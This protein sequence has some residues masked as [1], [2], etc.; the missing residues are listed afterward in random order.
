MAKSWKF[1]GGVLGGMLV[2]MIPIA[3][4]LWDAGVLPLPSFGSD[5]VE[6]HG[7][8][9]L[10]C[11]G[12]EELV[13]EGRK[14]HNTD[15]LLP[16]MISMGGNCQLRILGSTITGHKILWVGGNAKVYI[17]DS[18][19]NAT[20]T[21][22][23]LGGNAQLTLIRTKVGGKRAALHVAGNARV[24]HDEKSAFV[25]RNRGRTKNIVKATG[26]AETS[27]EAQAP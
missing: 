25:G 17:E 16:A 23:Y 15:K 19:L 13:L 18:E 8:K 6:W 3:Y 27:G 22:I 2:I 14:V 10:S 5:K 20:H 4:E 7:I 9:K 12:D 21:A 1:K 26:A 24:T 11:G